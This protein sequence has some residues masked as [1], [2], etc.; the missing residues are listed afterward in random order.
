METVTCDKCKSTVVVA[1]TK[2]PVC[3]EKLPKLLGFPKKTVISVLVILMFGLIF[4][5]KNKG[6]PAA[7]PATQEIELKLTNTQIINACKHYIGQLFGKPVEIIK[8]DFTK[9]DAGATF[10]QVSYVRPDD[11]TKWTYVCF[12]NENEI[13]WASVNNGDLGRWRWE[14]QGKI[15]FIGND[16]SK[17]VIKRDGHNDISVR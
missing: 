9:E 13:T 7:P 2:C 12:V 11:S 1:T 10:A 17:I 8:L 4:G 15:N 16:G 14:D 3:G 6:S 5:E